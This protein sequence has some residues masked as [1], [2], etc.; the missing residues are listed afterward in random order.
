[1]RAGELDAARMDADLQFAVHLKDMFSDFK[2]DQPERVGGRDVYQMIAS[3]PGKPPV[4][5][6]FDKE[7][8]LLLRLI[9]YVD[10]PLGLNPAR[11]DYEAYSAV[12]GVQVAHRWTI[13]RPN[14]RFTVQAVEIRQN[15]PVSDNKFAKPAPPSPAQ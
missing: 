3:N 13:A 8:G 9:R 7:S 1:M 4:Q 14:G 12:D 15:V 2:T 6:Y 5:L 10:S 11:I